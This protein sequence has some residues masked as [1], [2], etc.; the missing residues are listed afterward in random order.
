LAELTDRAV[1]IQKQVGRCGRT[2]HLFEFTQ[3][4]LSTPGV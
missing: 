1:F 3:E 2:C 4:I